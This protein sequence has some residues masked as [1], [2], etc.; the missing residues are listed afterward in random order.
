MFEDSL[1]ES[2]GKLA[3]RNPWSTLVSFTLQGALLGAA[4]LLSLIYTE[5]L[6]VQHWMN[7]LQVPPPPTAGAPVA[8]TA[9][10]SAAHNRST[11]DAFTL[12]REI[13]KHTDMQPHPEEAV[14]SSVG[15][16]SNIPGAI[17][18][19]SSSRINDL[20]RNAVPPAPKL[21]PPQKVR[22]SGGVAEGLLIYKVK[23][24]YLPL[25]I[26]ARVQGRVILQAVIGRDGSVQ[27]L[28]VIS[29]HPLLVASAMDAVRQW[30]YRPYLLSGEPVEVDT[31][32][33]VD[34]TLT[35]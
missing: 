11:D 18:E 34:F 10:T 7:I 20:L 14:Q 23:P 9:V 1:V 6:P 24:Q 27:N 30:R 12:P 21:V 15:V 19:G 32:I 33:N 2:T 31:T 26:Q 13:P 16:G 3:A 8:R 35:Q 25:A 28:R 29:G 4:L 5:T 17:P 22:V